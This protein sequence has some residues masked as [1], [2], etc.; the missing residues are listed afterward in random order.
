MQKHRV[1]DIAQDLISLLNNGFNLKKK[2]LKT[3]GCPEMGLSQTNNKVILKCVMCAG[4]R[5]LLKS[6]PSLDAVLDEYHLSHT[7]KPQ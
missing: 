7:S 3:L 5:A 1:N 6:T 4:T 2:G